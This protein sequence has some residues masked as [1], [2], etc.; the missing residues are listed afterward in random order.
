[1]EGERVG[2]VGRE[3]GGRNAVAGI[4]GRRAAPGRGRRQRRHQVALGVGERGGGEVEE[5]RIERDHCAR[6]GRGIGF[7]AEVGELGRERGGSVEEANNGEPP[8]RT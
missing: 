2:R 8:H 7:A 4:A 1:Q 3:R 5:E 6:R